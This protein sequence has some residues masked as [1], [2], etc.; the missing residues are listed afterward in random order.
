M[1][2]DNKHARDILTRKFYEGPPS[3]GDLLT[4]EAIERA[5]EVLKANNVEPN[6]DGCYPILVNPK[7]L[8]Y[9]HGIS[10]KLAWSENMAK[11]WAKEE[12]R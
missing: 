8:G 3:E 2:I 4:R 7:Q 10:L 6:K 12:K 5:V 1:I 9:V 11:R